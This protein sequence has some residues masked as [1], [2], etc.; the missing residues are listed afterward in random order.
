[1]GLNTET[2]AAVVFLTLYAILFILLL[3]GCLTR[4]IRLRSRYSIIF[5]YVMVRLASQCTGV[6]FGIK[7]YTAINLLIAYLIL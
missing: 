6:A 2:V 7:G 4:R 5:F 1:M 3:L